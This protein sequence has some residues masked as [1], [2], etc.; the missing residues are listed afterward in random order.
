MGWVNKSTGETK[1]SVTENFEDSAEMAFSGIHIVHP[2]VFE[3]LPEQ[4]K[5][6]IVQVYLELAKD[7]TIKGYF[8]ESD[9][10]MDVGKPRQLEEARKLF[11]LNFQ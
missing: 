11:P 6:S 7:H 3:L 4:D 8:D 1:I 2:K 9:L 5:F 10:W